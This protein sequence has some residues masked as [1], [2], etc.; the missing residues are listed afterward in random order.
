MIEKE[1]QNVPKAMNIDSI[2]KSPMSI[3]SRVISAPKPVESMEEIMKK[4][5]EDL[6]DKE[7]PNKAGLPTLILKSNMKSK[8]SDSSN[9]MVT[10]FKMKKN[11]FIYQKNL[12]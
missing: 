8:E 2:L 6:T 10:S 9:D 11:V 1:V 3:K 7:Q 4:I 12:Y 5:R